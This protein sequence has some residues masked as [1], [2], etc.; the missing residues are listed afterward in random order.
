MFKNLVNW[1]KSL[2]KELFV[3][4]VLS[5]LVGIVMLIYP[6]EVEKFICYVIGALFIICGGFA[7]GAI[8]VKKGA[9]PFTFRIIP[10]SLA[11]A[12]GFLFIFGAGFVFDVLWVFIGIGIIMN[13]YFKNQYAYELKFSGAQKWWINL[14]LSMISLALGVVLIVERDI[15]QMKMIRLAGIFLAVDGLCDIASVVTFVANYNR[16]RKEEKAEEKAK[17]MQEKLTKKEAKLAKRL[18]K[19]NKKVVNLEEVVLGSKA[20]AAAE[21][22]EIITEV[23]ENTNVSVEDTLEEEKTEVTEEAK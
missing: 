19:K 15:D 2:K 16:I 5:I 3:L 6:T 8:L 23:S 7:L 1:F 21:E 13:S 9:Q 4:G 17:A 11:V 14:A 10:A 12:I 22:T 20:E 18:A